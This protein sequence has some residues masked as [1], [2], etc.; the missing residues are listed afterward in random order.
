MYKP[1]QKVLCGGE[2]PRIQ[3]FSLK[4]LIGQIHIWPFYTNPERASALPLARYLEQNPEF[5]L[6]DRC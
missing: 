6:I 4:D 1:K 2:H 5:Q 3:K